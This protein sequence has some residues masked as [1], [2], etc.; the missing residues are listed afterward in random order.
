M[1]RKL[2]NAFDNLKNFDEKMKNFVKTLLFYYIGR[3]V[4]VILQK[5]SHFSHMMFPF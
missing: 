4:Y 1:K 3:F 2:E 5:R